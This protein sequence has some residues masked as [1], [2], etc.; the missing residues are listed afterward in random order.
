M[1]EMPEN[2]P[3]RIGDFEI[4]GMLGQGGY[5][6]VYAGVAP[7]GTKV[8]IKAL[9]FSGADTRLLETQVAAVRRVAPFCTA[10]VLGVTRA[11]NTLFVV[12]ELIEGPTLWSRVHDQGPL[13]G[14]A[15][16][17]LA[18]GT[19]TALAAIH[20][21]GVVHRDFK[22]SNILLS[23]DGPRVIDFGIARLTELTS[24]VPFAGTPSF[25]APEQ[26]L[27]ETVGP[28]ADVFSWAST[29]YFAATG[30]FPF[31]GASLP[32]TMQQILHAEPD[33]SGLPDELRDVVSRAFAKEPARR[34]TAEQLLMALLKRSDES[35]AKA[36]KVSAV[37][38]SDAVP[39]ARFDH[40]VPSASFHS[41]SRARS[42]WVPLVA[43]TAVVGTVL[44][45]TAVLSASL[46]SQP[47]RADVSPLAAVISAILIL[48]LAAG[49]AISWRLARIRISVP[50]TRIKRAN[51]AVSLIKKGRRQ[52]GVQQLRALLPEL[53]RTLGSD[54]PDTLAVRSNLA[55]LDADPDQ[56][57]GTVRTLTRILGADH[58]QTLT[59]RANLALLTQDPDWP[60][61]SV[62]ELRALLLELERTL[63]SDHPD[64]LA[65]RSNLAA[66]DADPDQLR[67]TVRT[68][69][70]ILGADH[71]Q[72]LTARANLA[73]TLARH[74]DVAGAETELRAVFEQRKRLLGPDHADTKRT[75]TS[76]DHLRGGIGSGDEVNP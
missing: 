56:L 2:D 50:R 28:E 42:S 72:T 38:V 34:P 13:T 46:V 27:G 26:L 3:R 53:E 67:G 52:Q 66:L 16:M 14:S 6:A 48:C 17:R 68:L 37:S 35:S 61:Q 4:V 76:L 62:Q 12:S 39:Q 57:R 24:T 43:S 5:G 8:A 60:D 18:I 63:G 10:R 73:A 75:A 59:A 25:M 31:V 9:R 19:A 1:T 33:V 70:R 44:A 36:L 11:D 22:P 58:A 29:M 54:H 65:V 74:G 21:A 41:P 71:A 64:T 30:R 69:T 40:G 15:L 32:A 51:R 49:V 47:G 45:G 7:D 23:P 20:Q 55:A